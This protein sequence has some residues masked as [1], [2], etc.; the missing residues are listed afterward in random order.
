MTVMLRHAFFITVVRPLVFVFLG[1]NVRNRQLLPDGGPA[2]V[3]ANH[4]SHLDTLV[5]M[6][7]F[8]MRHLKAVRPVA[9]AD[10][11]LK[12]RWI[13]WF[14]NTILRIVPVERIKDK[15]TAPSDPLKGISQALSDGSILIFFPE[16][17]RGEAEKLTRFRSGIARL[18]ERHP[19]VPVVPVFLHGLGKSLPR[20]EGVL[21]PFICDVFVGQAMRWKENSEGFLPKLEE[22]VE[23]LAKQARLSNWD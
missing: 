14:A 9:A 20:G 4:N 1:V 19:E 15:S 17:S 18:A 10:Y 21:I 8:P 11:W 7:L 12:N 2:V 6:A 3:V 23:D 13:G 16:G 5:L 22:R